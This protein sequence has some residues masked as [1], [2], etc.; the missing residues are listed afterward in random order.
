MELP[1]LFIVTV[2][3]F[4]DELNNLCGEYFYITLIAIIK[5]VD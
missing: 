5:V 4:R 1:Y 2:I 3:Y